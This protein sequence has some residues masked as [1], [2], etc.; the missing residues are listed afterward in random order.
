MKRSFV[1]EEYKLGKKCNFYA[2]RFDSE[3]YS[4]MDQFILDYENKYSDE[5]SSILAKIS[6][7][8]EYRG[9]REK[10]FRYENK[11]EDC[12]VAL[13]EKDGEKKYLRLYCLR[14]CTTCVIL[15]IGAVKDP[16]ADK[17]K[18][19]EIPHI[20]DIMEFMKQL[21]DEIDN[22]MHFSVKDIYYEDDCLCGD[23]RF[24]FSDED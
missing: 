5:I 18:N 23:L 21:N 13:P 12:I 20:K 17:H 16:N 10:H 6:D 3:E 24:D 2:I 22:R 19:H 1:I 9:A 4:A 14:L 15:G 7:M 11:K 8:A